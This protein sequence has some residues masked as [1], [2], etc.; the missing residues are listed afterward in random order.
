MNG[1]TT[2]TLESS[3]LCVTKLTFVWNDILLLTVLTVS[4]EGEKL[5][6]QI[7]YVLSVVCYLIGIVRVQKGNFKASL[8]VAVYKKP[9]RRNYINFVD[10]KHQIPIRNLFL[11]LISQKP[12]VDK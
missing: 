4:F 10:Q 6:Y 5:S 7:E 9:S 12:A 8:Y 3:F 1:S 11:I 2:S